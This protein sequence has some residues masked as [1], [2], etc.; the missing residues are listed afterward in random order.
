MAW[1]GASAFEVTRLMNYTNYDSSY[2][3]KPKFSN[4]VHLASRASAVLW[5]GD[6]LRWRL[7]V[8]RRVSN[9][10]FLKHYV[11]RALFIVR[12]SH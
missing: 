1:E 9:I 5:G 12:I 7:S 8:Y 4:I 10:V 2:M 6:S 3:K 11:S